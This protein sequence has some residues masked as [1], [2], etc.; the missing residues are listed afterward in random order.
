M[1]VKIYYNHDLLNEFSKEHNIV[2]ND[3]LEHV[4]CNTKIISKCIT[5]ECNN[6]YEKKFHILFKTK[7]FFCKKCTINNGVIK[8]KK[9]I[10]EKY[11]VDCIF[12]SNQIREKITEN[13]IKKYGV[14]NPSK[15]K[16]VKN[17]MME[18]KINKYHI[19]PK[20]LLTKE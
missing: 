13:N 18:T 15:L 7:N 19:K 12:Q 20:I 4:N 9:T 3:I 17:K 6:N 1:P 2:L 5:N 11:G 10:Q 8:N 16:E 14:D